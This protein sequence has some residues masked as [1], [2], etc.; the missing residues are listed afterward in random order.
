VQNKNYRTA[1]IDGMS[2]AGEACDTSI[3][4]MIVGALENI[5]I[6]GECSTT[7]NEFKPP[8]C[9][10]KKEIKQVWQYNNTKAFYPKQIICKNQE[11]EK[12]QRERE[13]VH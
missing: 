12:P 4:S 13:V 8:S 10:I 3:P 2:D 5:G 6:E 11:A 9:N 1:A 7:S